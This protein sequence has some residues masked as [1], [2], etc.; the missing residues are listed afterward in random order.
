MSDTLAFAPERARPEASGTPWQVLVVD[1]DPEVHAVTRLMLENCEFA[2][3]RLTLLHAH[4]AA[5]ARTR[6]GEHPG[7]ALVLLDVV[8]ETEH[9]GLD[10]ARHIRQELG[11]HA[12]RIVLR[13]GQPGQTPVQQ[14]VAEYDID[15][16]LPKSELRFQRL[17]ILA[18]TTLRTY[19]LL[20]EL[21][22]KQ[23]ELR[24]SNEELERFAFTDTLTGLMNRRRFDVEIESEWR[25]AVRQHLPVT[26]LMIDVDCFK[27]YNDNYGHPAGDR[28]LQKVAKV[29]AEQLRRASDSVC[30]YGG[31]EFLA[32]LPGTA[33]AEG[34][35]IAEHVRQQVMALGLPHAHSPHGV[36]T[37]SVGCACAQP[38][39]HPAPDAAQPDPASPGPAPGAAPTGYEA[40]VRAADRGLYRAKNLGRNSVAVCPDD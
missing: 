16:Y 40:L 4:S 26:A 20:R 25:R 3:R 14:V 13:T 38:V 12:I 10:V 21:E 24:R 5:E 23:A 22:A 30:R 19:A 17:H 34:L 35:Q 33:L 6:L 9:A 8:M 37:I 39:Q 28:V 11:N 31:E 15:D 7:I 32:L 2:G 1:D 36:V 27:T 29:L 18:T